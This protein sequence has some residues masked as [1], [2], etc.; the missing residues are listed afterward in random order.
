MYCEKRI[1][2][3]YPPRVEKTS[4][5]QRLAPSVAIGTDAH[6]G[7]RETEIIAAPISTFLNMYYSYRVGLICRKN[8]KPNAVRELPRG[9][10]DTR[11][12]R[13]TCQAASL[14]A[15]LRPQVSLHRALE[16]PDSRADHWAI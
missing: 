4:Y 1:S 2:Q 6:P 16:Q 12:A 9:Q 10:R 8:V 7:N 14:V 11:S 5:A 13:R 15:R 3:L